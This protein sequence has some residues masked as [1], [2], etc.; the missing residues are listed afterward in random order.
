[1]QQVRN[2]TIRIRMLKKLRTFSEGV[3][4]TDVPECGG[5]VEEN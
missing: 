1:M 3:A 2:V 4:H 5:T